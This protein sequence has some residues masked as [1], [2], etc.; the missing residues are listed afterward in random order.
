M[1][2][3]AS[4]SEAVALADG[5]A[6]AAGVRASRCSLRL[7]VPALRVADAVAV[8][9]DTPRE[10]LAVVVDALATA[11]PLR[12]TAVAARPTTMRPSRRGGAAGV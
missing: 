2:A 9:L 6:D 5:D 10:A 4:A 1:A 11:T 7:V 12:P 8:L 3:S